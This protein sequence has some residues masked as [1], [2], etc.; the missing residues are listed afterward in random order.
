MNGSS[1][2][3][4]I[5]LWN[6]DVHPACNIL[7]HLPL[8]ASLVLGPEQRLPA[9]S[10]LQYGCCRIVTLHSLAHVFQGALTQLE[11]CEQ[12]RQEGSEDPVTRGVRES[13]GGGGGVALGRHGSSPS[14]QTSSSPQPSPGGGGS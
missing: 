10:A 8:R 9:G 3:L 5:L 6:A 11:G 2:A 1:K 12:P 7:R 4:A 13:K 14:H